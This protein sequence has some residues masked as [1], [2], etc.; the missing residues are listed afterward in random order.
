MP[1]QFRIIPPAGK[2]YV[3][4]YDHKLTIAFTDVGS[5][6]QLLG[7]FVCNTILQISR[8]VLIA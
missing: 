6:E 8:V 7:A 2:S 5:L 3:D 1:F 4:S